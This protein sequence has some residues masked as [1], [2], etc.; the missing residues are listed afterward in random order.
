MKDYLLFSCTAHAELA[1]LTARE[2]GLSL[3]ASEMN[4]FP[5]GEIS[6]LR[7]TAIGSR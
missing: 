4:R 6:A 3:S 1:A 2:A 7:T 5:D